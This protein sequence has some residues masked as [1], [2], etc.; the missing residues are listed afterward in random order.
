VEPLK[1]DLPP[2]RELEL[3][4]ARQRLTALREALLPLHKTLIESERVGYE[5]SFGPIKSPGDFLQL[6]TRDPWFAWLQPLSELITSI[7]E[8]LDSETPLSGTQTEQFFRRT[9]ELLVAAET[10][11]GFAR[12]Y[13]DALQRD[14]DV[15]MAHARVT[16]LRSRKPN[17]GPAGPA[18]APAT[19]G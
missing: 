11:T 1:N 17:A 8:A 3:Q 12:H 15:V 7:D 18:S 5:A 6:L 9:G 4:R 10:G 16:Q 19:G 14:P 13:H 2:D